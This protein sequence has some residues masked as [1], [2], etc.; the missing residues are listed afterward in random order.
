MVPKIARMRQ[1]IKSIQ[2]FIASDEKL[3]SLN[4][5][6]DLVPS[7]WD[8]REMLADRYDELGRSAFARLQRY[9]VESGKC[10][11]IYLQLSRNHTSVNI[12]PKFPHN[13][14][15]ISWCWGSFPEGSMNSLP[16][17]LMELFDQTTF[18]SRIE[19]EYTLLCGLRELGAALLVREMFDD[20]RKDEN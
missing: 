9:M 13:A 14:E 15:S 7:D 11:A 3:K 2:E 6:L 20:E 4:Q 18:D 17:P 19:A 10:P 5:Y 16:K 1:E 12:T 8:R